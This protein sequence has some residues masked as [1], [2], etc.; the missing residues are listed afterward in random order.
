MSILSEVDHRTNLD[1]K[2]FLVTINLATI[3]SVTD[4]Q[5]SERCKA[6]MSEVYSIR[7]RANALTE[8]IKANNVSELEA[9][10]EAK[11]LECRAAKDRYDELSQWKGQFDETGRRLGVELQKAQNRRW[12]IKSQPPVQALATRADNEAYKQRVEDAE[13]VVQNALDALYG[14]Q[15][16]VDD[17]N[18]KC[19]EAGTIF[20]NLVIEEAEIRSR[21]NT[22][23]GITETVA[24]LRRS[25]IGL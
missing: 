12:E 22:L 2:F 1:D 15:R 18:K 19:N 20:N 17:Y 16:M 11:V 7:H 14:H 23:T 21:L 25:E 6:I 13:N 8:D 5:L 24:V 3:A 10:R 9:A 4:G